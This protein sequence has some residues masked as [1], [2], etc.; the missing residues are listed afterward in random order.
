MVILGEEIAGTDG[1]LDVAVALPT[2]LTTPEFAV[3]KARGAGEFGETLVLIQPIELKESFEVD[4]DDD[5]VPEVCDNCSSDSNADQADSDGD[6]VGD[7]CDSCPTDPTNQCVQAAEAFCG[8]VDCNGKRTAS[9]ALL[10]L[11]KAVGQQASVFCPIQC[12]S[13][14]FDALPVGSEVCGDTNCNG[15]VTAGDALSVLKAAVGQSVGLMCG[16]QC[17]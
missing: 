9:D 14:L 11:K 2:T 7:V 17:E 4:Q 15:S 13:G 8:D 1:R 10:M 12:Q 5:D 3:L 6:G 16:V